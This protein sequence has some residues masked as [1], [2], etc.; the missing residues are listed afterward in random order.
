MK[1][2]LTRREK[3]Y[4]AK[5][6]FFTKRHTQKEICAMVGVT[7]ATM[8]KWVKRF[9]WKKPDEAGLRAN[10]QAFSIISHGFNDYLEN[11]NPELFIAVR[12]EIKSYLKNTSSN[13]AKLLRVKAE[14]KELF[15]D[16][17]LIG[18]KFGGIT[19]DQ[20]DALGLIRAERLL[21]LF[22]YRNQPVIELTIKEVN[23]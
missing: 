7:D 18:K 8:S 17:E 21:E 22:K 19:V 11:N 6:L 4:R 15:N 9:G 3:R 13:G 23:T 2:Q 16:P 20:V 10:V 12:N 5:A 1:K 14:I